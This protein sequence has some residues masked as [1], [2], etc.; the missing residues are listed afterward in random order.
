MKKYIAIN[1]QRIKQVNLNDNQ[2]N[3][4]PQEYYKLPLLDMCVEIERNKM[5]A[6]QKEDFKEIGSTEKTLS[7][8]WLYVSRWVYKQKQKTANETKLKVI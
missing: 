2:N 6:I 4:T 5:F 1:L 7:R 8:C 3:I